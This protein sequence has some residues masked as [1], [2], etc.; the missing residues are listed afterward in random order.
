MRFNAEKC[1]IMSIKKG[2]AKPYLYELCNT[3]LSSVTAEKYLGV[4]LTQEMSW[5]AHISSIT[6]KANQKLGFLRRNMKGSPQECRKLA[7]TALLRPCLH[8]MG[9]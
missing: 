2:Q 9:P 5:S 6:T 4:M 3:I 8:H 1:H 7:Y